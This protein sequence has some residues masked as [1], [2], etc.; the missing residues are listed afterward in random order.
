MV[1]TLILC[2]VS[3]LVFAVARVLMAGK[4]TPF[5]ID[6]VS[7]FLALLVFASQTFLGWKL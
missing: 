1:E 7:L 3:S 2:L 6:F 5:W 4:T